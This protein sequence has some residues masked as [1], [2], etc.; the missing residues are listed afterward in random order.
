MDLQWLAL[1][2][3]QLSDIVNLKSLKLCSRTGVG[4]TA[5]TDDLLYYLSLWSMHVLGKIKRRK[6]RK[7][8]S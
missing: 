1:P 2:R 3:P 6:N 5:W 8:T 4:V 7:Q